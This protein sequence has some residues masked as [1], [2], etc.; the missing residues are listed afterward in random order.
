MSQL[1]YVVTHLCAKQPR[2]TNGHQQQGQ[3]RLAF[4]AVGGCRGAEERDQEDVSEQ[5]NPEA[6]APEAD[7]ESND[8]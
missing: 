1:F 7:A 3:D 6:V 5:A 4:A 8:R 2:D